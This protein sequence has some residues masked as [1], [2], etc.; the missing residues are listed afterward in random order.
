L[1]KYEVK[2]NSAILAEAK[3]IPVY[4]ELVSK[5][6][7][8]YLAGGATQNS[9]RVAQWFLPAGSTTYI[10]S[11]GKDAYGEQLRKSAEADGVSTHYSEDEKT[12][13]GT[14][15]CL[16]VHKERA[17]IAHLSAAN[18]YRVTHL[19]RPDS[20]ARWLKADIIYSAGFFLTVSPDSALLLAKHC[21][22][23]G[24]IYATNLSAAFI[25]EF[26]TAALQAV[27][28]YSDFVFGNEA[29]AKA[30]STKLAWGTDKIAEIAKRTAALPKEG[31][32]ARIV[33]FTQGP[34]ETIV[35]TGDTVETYPVPAVPADQI[36][37]VNGAG[38]AFVGGFLSGLLKGKSIADCVRIGH[39]AARVIIG[40]SGC[41]L[42]GR[43]DAAYC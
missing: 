40:V 29:E 16:I 32:R 27:L 36:V 17:L 21:H 15:A 39:Y 43:P 42:H 5:Y 28:P 3:H 22:A 24:K 26:F 7:V 25:P 41:V 33:V 23:A 19:L 8:Q 1:T 18:E 12:P 13:T 20:V 31:K 30:L 9:I 35:V 34:S 4:A 11:I 2:L 6:S 38:D 14:C 10:G 37:D